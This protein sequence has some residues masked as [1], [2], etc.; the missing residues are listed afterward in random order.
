MAFQGESSYRGENKVQFTQE[1]FAEEIFYLA[2]EA[3][4]LF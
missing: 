1:E 3:A 4:G 2:L